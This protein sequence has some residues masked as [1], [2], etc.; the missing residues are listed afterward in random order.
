MHL[1]SFAPQI[2]FRHQEFHSRSK[3]LP[4]QS[5]LLQA[6]VHW[7]AKQHFEAVLESY[8]DIG[9]SAC[10]VTSSAVH[11]EANKLS[12]GEK[13]V[14]RSP[15]SPCHLDNT[16]TNL[17]EESCNGKY[18]YSQ[19]AGIRVPGRDEVLRARLEVVE[20]VLLVAL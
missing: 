17:Q 16:F 12:F 11:M 4:S 18:L 1:V 19:L 5:A 2:R 9:S 10:S 6:L 13:D 20:H 8:M 14:Q 7:A 15:T 3:Y